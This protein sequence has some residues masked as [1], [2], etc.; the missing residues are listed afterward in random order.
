MHRKTCQLD[1]KH[2]IRIILL[3]YYGGFKCCIRL[4][5]NITWGERHGMSPGDLG[6]NAG[7]ENLV[8]IFETCCLET[9]LS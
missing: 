5:K 6:L 2:E 1:D 4:F 7:F 9:K 8:V 3:R